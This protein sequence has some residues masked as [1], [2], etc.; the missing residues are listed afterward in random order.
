[1]NSIRK[2]IEENDDTHL[3]GGYSLN[4]EIDDTAKRQ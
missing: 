2:S 4:T 3:P 1:M